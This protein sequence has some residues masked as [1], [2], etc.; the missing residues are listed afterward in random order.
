MIPCPYVQLWELSRLDIGFTIF[1]FILNKNK[2]YYLDSQTVIIY[3]ELKVETTM[4]KIKV[5]S[6]RP[7]FS[8]KLFKLK[9]NKLKKRV[10]ENI[11]TIGDPSETDMLDRRST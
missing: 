6:I 1:Q 4:I 8:L 3:V 10:H 7:H 11:I 2:N 5:S 9:K